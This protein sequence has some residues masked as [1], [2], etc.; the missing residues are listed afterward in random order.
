MYKVKFYNKALEQYYNIWTYIAED[1]IFYAKE[2]I[3]KIDSSISIIA[4]YPFIWNEIE[5]W[6]RR[7]T[8]PRY[9]YKIVYEIKWN[10]IYIIS[11]FK[12]KNL[13]E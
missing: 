8:E 1:N 10:I 11:V 4:E 2:V 13:W 5:Q 3:D 7:I 12:Y 9:K 6:I